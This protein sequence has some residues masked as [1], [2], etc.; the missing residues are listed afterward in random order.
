MFDNRTTCIKF[1]GFEYKARLSGLPTNPITAPFMNA[2]IGWN[3]KPTMTAAQ[4]TAMS[5]VNIAIIDGTW[6]TSSTAMAPN[7]P[8]W[9]TVG[10]TKVLPRNNVNFSSVALPPTN[11]SKQ[12]VGPSP[13]GHIHPRCSTMSPYNS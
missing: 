10:C 2:S 3:T 11:Y 9:N 8:K 12:R 5:N 7:S 1:A 6:N 4:I 13:T